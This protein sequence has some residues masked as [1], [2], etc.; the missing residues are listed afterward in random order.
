MTG[1]P[2]PRMRFISGK[3]AKGAKGANI[4]LIPPPKSWVKSVPIGLK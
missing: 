3:G 1:L 2:A 4:F